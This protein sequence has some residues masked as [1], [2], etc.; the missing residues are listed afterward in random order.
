MCVFCIVR[1]NPYDV[2]PCGSLEGY[3]E[4]VPHAVTLARARIEADLLSDQTR[5]LSNSAGSCPH[6]YAQQELG[7]VDMHNCD[8]YKRRWAWMYFRLH[9]K[10]LIN[11]IVDISNM[12]PKS[13]KIID[14]PGSIDTGEADEVNKQQPESRLHFAGVKASLRFKRRSSNPQILCRYKRRSD[15]F[16]LPC[17]THPTFDEP[18]QGQSVSFLYN[19]LASKNRNIDS[20]AQASERFARSCGAYCVAT[21]LLGIGDRHSDN[22]M[23][24][25]DGHV[26]LILV[27][28]NA[29][30]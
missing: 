19:W 30:L 27:F 29:A 12:L 4:V 23:I 9:K 11:S 6:L 18:Q 28:A 17:A 13:A 10:R 1:L 21:F 8:P 20:M 22:L 7:S 3:V 26:R 14:Q 25:E 5:L 2:L 15:Q 24:T 16:L